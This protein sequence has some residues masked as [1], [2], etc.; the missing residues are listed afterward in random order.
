MHPETLLVSAARPA[1]E[2]DAPVNEPVHFTST[3]V[4]WES[5]ATDRRVYGRMSNPSWEGPEHLL[6]ALEGVEDPTATPALLFSSGMGAIAAALHLVP[7]GARVVAPQHAYNG[8]TSLLASLRESG[9]LAVDQV[10]ITDLAAVEAALAGTPAPGTPDAGPAGARGPAAILWLESPTNPMLEVADLRALAEAAHA[11]GALVVVDNTFATPLVQ[12]PLELGADVVVHSVTKYLAGHSD[13]V[14]GAAVTR[15]PAL[16]ARL[17][18][19]RTLH[20]AI[21][22]PMEAFLALRGMRTLALRLERSQ[23]TAA[24]LAR[25]AEAARREGAL[26]L[27]AVRYPGL[28]DHPQHAIA[29]EQ[30]HGGFGSVLTLEVAGPEGAGDEEVAAVADAMVTALRLWV[31]AT[32]LGGV[33]SLVERRRRFAA[34]P[35]TVPAGLLRLSCG[36]EHVEDLWEDLVHGLRAA[37]AAGAGPR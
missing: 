3:F 29:A 23:A 33:E 21:A 32:S 22:G 1:K 37:A 36:I 11:A 30:M 18:E 9:R 8:L 19:H 7:T 25:R 28:P 34:E 15:D 13:V 27:A 6:A 16:H 5:G 20:G 31:P 14:L 2:V 4:G 10:D 17:L 24:E 12:R 35:R 26:P